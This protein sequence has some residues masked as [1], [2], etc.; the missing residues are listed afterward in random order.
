MNN[1][2]NLKRKRKN[3]FQN[4]GGFLG[5]S[6][7]ITNPIVSLSGQYCHTQFGLGTKKSAQ[8]CRGDGKEETSGECNGWMAGC[9]ISWT[10]KSKAASEI[11]F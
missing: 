7:L 4:P 2:N 10:D 8:K 3:L 5:E 1:V 6:C 11:D 9:K